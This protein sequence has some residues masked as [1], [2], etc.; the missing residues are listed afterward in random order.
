M[1]L[2]HSFFLL[3]VLTLMAGPL[4]AQSVDDTTTTSPD[5]PAPGSTVI[6]SDELRM[7][8]VSHV[9]VFTGN[10][11]ATGTNFVMKCQE[12]TVNFDKAGKVDT[13]VSKGDVV[14]TQP[15]RVTH[16]GQ[17]EYYRDEDK[18]VLTDQPTI[19]D[20]GNLISAPV[21]TIYRT[22]QS[23]YTSGGKSRVTLKPG[24][25]AGPATGSTSDGSA[26]P[27]DDSDKK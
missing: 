22:K 4:R 25:G 21:I 2:L 24:S 18:F 13:I 27:T 14:V 3:A 23:L 20:N 15:G 19:L 1:K 26:L 9:A 16:S 11:V 10:V 6:T 12:M 8:Q 5:T 17:A 7:D